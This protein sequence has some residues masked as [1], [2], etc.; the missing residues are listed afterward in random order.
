M[1]GVVFTALADMV[2]EQ[3]GL[4]MW[5]QLLEEAALPSQGAYTAGARYDDEELLRLVTLLSQHTGIAAADLVRS[6]GTFLFGQLYASLPPDLKSCSN[7][8]EFLLKIDSTIHKEVKRVYP[9]SYLPSFKYDD[10]KPNELT[11]YYQ[12]R[13]KMCFAAEGLIEGAARQ[14]STAI[15]LQ[16]PVCMHHGAESCTLV[17]Q[18]LDPQ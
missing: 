3:L 1:Q 10:S 18:F 7:L 8:R 4:P 2:I 11:M 15:A 9:D 5:E 13:R 6:F 17:V 16:H 12:S 14:F